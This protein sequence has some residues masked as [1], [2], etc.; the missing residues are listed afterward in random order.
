MLTMLMIVLSI[1]FSPEPAPVGC[2]PDH[3]V[4]VVASGCTPSGCTKTCTR[5][6]GRRS[7]RTARQNR[8]P[9]LMEMDPN[10]ITLEAQ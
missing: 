9:G 3:P 6:C 5:G 4:V 2:P 7:V 8:V 10:A 1:L